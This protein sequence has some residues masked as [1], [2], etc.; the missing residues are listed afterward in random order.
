MPN[1]RSTDIMMKGLRKL[2]FSPFLFS[3]II[4]GHP[5]N[6]D[7]L[8]DDWE[9]VPI[10]YSDQDGDA[11]SYI[12]VENP[13]LVFSILTHLFFERP[14]SNGCISEYA[15]VNTKSIIKENVQI[16]H[17]AIIK[18]NAT[19]SKNVI[20]SE[21]TIIGPNVLIGENSQIASNSI[22]ESNVNIGEN[23]IIG[24]FVIIRNSII[25]KDVYVQD[26][27]KIGVKGFGFIPQK[28][29]NKITPH[30][31]KVKL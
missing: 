21:N 6:I 31:G 28:N 24:S 20:I 11:L 13:Y 16:N 26:G 23:C 8:F 5:I 7:G 1:H 14:K 18:E 17:G 30:V 12:I 3:L 22:I 2:F 27:A 29:K 10:A 25:L 9:D 19:I 4:A 15:Y